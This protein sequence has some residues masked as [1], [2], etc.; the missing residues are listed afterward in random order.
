MFYSKNE[1]EKIYVEKQ[2]EYGFKID[3]TVYIFKKYDQFP[4]WGDSWVDLM[5]ETLYK[6][7]RIE[8]I[9]GTGGIRVKVNGIGSHYYP[10]ASL[11]KVQT[12]EIC[13]INY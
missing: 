4:G 8:A 9:S 10:Y 5:D 12:N 7:G 2:N 1:E 13:E 6:C 3:D 11:I